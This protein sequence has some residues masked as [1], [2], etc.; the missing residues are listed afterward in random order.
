MIIGVC[1]LFFVA[2]AL[3]TIL[4]FEAFELKFNKQYAAYEREKR[5]QIFAAN[6]AKAEAKNAARKHPHAATFGATHVADLT[7]DEFRQRYLMPADG[8]L[9]RVYNDNKAKL[10]DANAKAHKKRAAVPPT[11]S[12]ATKGA[13]TAINDQQQCGSCWA[14]STIENVESVAIL[15]GKATNTSI[16]LAPQQLVDCCDLSAGC[17]GGF[18]EG[19]YTCIEWEKGI[20]TAAQYPY[21]GQT[22]TCQLTNGVAVAGSLQISG[23]TWASGLFDEHAMQAALVTSAP[24]S[25]CVD[26][27]DWQTYTGGVFTGDQDPNPLSLDHCVQLVGYNETAPVPYWIVRNSWCAYHSASHSVSLDLTICFCCSGA[28]GFV[29]V[30]TA[31]DV[32]A[33]VRCGI[34][35]KHS[36]DVK[37]ANCTCQVEKQMIH[38]ALIVLLSSFLPTWSSV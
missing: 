27:S 16:D 18:P 31:R 5:R 30:H 11:W 34:C 22:G 24:L 14:W 38:V 10:A 29:R 35:S 28:M 2:T 21:T 20:E 1:L 4:S 12:W 19:G 6:M 13:V 9:E 8:H 26:A 17:N 25:I 37:R 33:N 15:A 32:E 3:C 36:H 23:W 7:H